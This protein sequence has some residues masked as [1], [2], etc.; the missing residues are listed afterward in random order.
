[1]SCL[2]IADLVRGLTEW[3][4]GTANYYFAAFISKIAWTDGVGHNAGA[5]VTTTVLPGAT[6][7]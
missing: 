2:D 4:D 3:S 5:S 7:S 1:M 6:T